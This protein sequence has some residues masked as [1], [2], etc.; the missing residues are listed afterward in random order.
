MCLLN[1]WSLLGNTVNIFKPTANYVQNEKQTDKQTKLKIISFCHRAE[2]IGGWL[3][4]SHL[5]KLSSDRTES[6]GREQSGLKIDIGST[7]KSAS[8]PEFVDRVQSG[9]ETKGLS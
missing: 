1:R 8:R 3:P 7:R 4:F 2:G 9:S 6:F 5:A